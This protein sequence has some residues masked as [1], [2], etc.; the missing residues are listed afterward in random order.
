MKLA[1]FSHQ[2]ATRVG[3]VIDGG[4]VDLALVAPDLPRTL[5]GLL[6]AGPDALEAPQC[7]RLDEGL[8]RRVVGRLCHPW[9]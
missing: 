5:H 7:E 9:L 6:I 4:V 3:V 8:V 1:T 2:G